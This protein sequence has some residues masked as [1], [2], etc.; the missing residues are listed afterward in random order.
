MSSW[1][2]GQLGEVPE[3][4]AQV[5]GVPLQPRTIEGGFDAKF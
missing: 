1:R 4:N 5:R 2:H 3:E